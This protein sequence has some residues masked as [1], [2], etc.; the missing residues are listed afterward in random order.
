M[1][2][3]KNLQ[4]CKLCVR[5]IVT[6]ATATRTEQAAKAKPT[7]EAATAPRTEAAKARPTAA[8]ATAGETGGGERARRRKAAATATTD[9]G[10]DGKTDGGGEGEADGGSGEGATARAEATAGD[11]G[12]GEGGGDRRNRNNSPTVREPGREVAGPNRTA[13]R[14]AVVRRARRRAQASLSLP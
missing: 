1:Y 10:G 6:A 4:M 7:A 14:R 13:G 5:R 9:G 3:K 2:I 11:D 12:G 8:T